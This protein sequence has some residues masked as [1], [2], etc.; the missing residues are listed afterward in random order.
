MGISRDSVHKRRGTGGRR[1][2]I[3]MKRKFEL[4]R[5][6][7]NTKIG[8]KKVSRV[9][10]RGG[11]FK[12]RALRLDAGNFAWT[13][14]AVTRKTRILNVVYNA[15]SNEYVRTNTLIK[16]AIVQVD[17]TP[18]KQWYNQHYNVALGKKK[19]EVAAPAAGETPAKQSRNVKAKIAKRVSG[20]IVDPAIDEQFVTGRL[21][22]RIAS[23][24]GQS[25]RCDG[26]VLEGEE[27]KF[28]L[29][30][31]NVKKRK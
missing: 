12:Y 25:G 10:V 21:Y 13:S 11:A 19:D 6:P 15:T 2:R 5:Q 20:K 31:L 16:G 1:I 28:Y 23:R 27:L 14:E 26:Y 17:A 8:E 24:P 7:A 18:Y 4:G 29:H 30:K 3:R 9:R 22:A